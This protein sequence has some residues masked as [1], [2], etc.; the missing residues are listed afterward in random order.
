MCCCLRCVVCW[1]LAVVFW[2][3]LVVACCSVFIGNWLLF[4]VLVVCVA[5]AVFVA[6]VVIV[7]RGV[8]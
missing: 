6:F 2:C 4:G 8:L 3:L 1:L 7:V 5:R